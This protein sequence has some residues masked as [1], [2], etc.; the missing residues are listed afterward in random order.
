MP[1]AEPLPDSLGIIR[2]LIRVKETS[3]AYRFVQDWLRNEG[4]TRAEARDYRHA[5]P[6]R[7]SIW[8]RALDRAPLHERMWR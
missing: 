3:P 5:P 4:I 7:P 1:D 2:T 6:F 8:L